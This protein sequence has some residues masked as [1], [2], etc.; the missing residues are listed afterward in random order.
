MKSDKVETQFNV[1]QFNNEKFNFEIVNLSLAETDCVCILIEKNNIKRYKDYA[2]TTFNPAG[3]WF[4]TAK[5]IE[6]YFENY[7]WIGHD[8]KQFCEQIETIKVKENTV[9][10]LT[11]EQQRLQAIQTFKEQLGDKINWNIYEVFATY[12]FRNYMI[13]FKVLIQSEK[14]H[15]LRHFNIV[16]RNRSV[17]KRYIAKYLNI[18]GLDSKKNKGKTFTEILSEHGHTLISFAADS[19]RTKSR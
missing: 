5:T 19:A 4:Q 9:N 15:T 6:D 11:K 1:Q 7:F 14:E 16:V 3:R 10:Q 17:A 8:I 13:N 12:P 18:T 2:L